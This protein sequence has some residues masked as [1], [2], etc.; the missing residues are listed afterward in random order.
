MSTTLSRLTEAV[1][2]VAPIDG[3]AILPAGEEIDPAWHL[4]TNDT[5]GTPTLIRIDYRPE[6][7]AQQI[8]DGD[9]VA[10]AFDLNEGER[11]PRSVFAIYAD[12]TGASGLTAAQADAVTADLGLG[13]LTGK[14][15]QLRPPQDAPAAALRWAAVNLGG[16]TAAEK[17]QA[18][19]W[20][21]AMWMQQQVSYLVNPTFHPSLVGLNI[22]GD[23]LV[24]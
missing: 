15:T 12:L 24:G 9:A 3:V 2:A 21:V 6:A 14:W 8:T 11:R 20:I 4:V 10:A 5:L 18:A 16:A 13:T 19:A 23:E 1:A 17:R 7:T 22:P